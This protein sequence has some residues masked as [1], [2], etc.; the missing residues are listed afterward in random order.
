MPVSERFLAMYFS[1]RN[2]H[3]VERKFSFCN[4]FRPIFLRSF[5]MYVKI[6]Q[7]EVLPSTKKQW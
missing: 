6:L 3:L 4:S 1:N 5:H 7:Q 2:R